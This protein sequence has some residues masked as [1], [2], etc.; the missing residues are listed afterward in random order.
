MF[1]LVGMTS[2]LSTIEL[3]HWLMIAGTFLLLLGLF[4][5]AVR[6]RGVEAEPDA[7]AIERDFKLRADESPEA[8]YR[9]VA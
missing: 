2:V 3:P 6:Q 1:G 8:F 5:L 7:V 4:G 9:L